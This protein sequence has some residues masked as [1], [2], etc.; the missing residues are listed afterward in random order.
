MNLSFNPSLAQAYQS[1]SQ[2]IRVLSENWVF[3]QIYCPSCGSEI[4]RAKSG[5][6]VFDFICKDCREEFELKSKKESLGKKI[7]DGAY[8]T[9]MERLKSPN[10]PNLFLLNY[11]A[12]NY[13]VIN[14]LVI[15]KHFFIPE[16]IESRKPTVVTGRKNVWIGCNI[17]MDK[18][19]E[20]GRIFFVRNQ[21]VEPKPKVL[22]VW[23][24]ALFLRKEKSTQSKGW[25]LDTM[26]CIDSLGKKEFSLDQIYMFE[27]ELRKKYPNNKHIKDKL[28]Q[29]LQILRD[30]GYIDFITPGKYKLSH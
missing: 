19:P 6:P 13:K 24:K 10:N 16:L 11:Q 27:T 25:I 8:Q 3:H 9:M 7:L 2:K 1:P 18:I 5:S 21:V 26:K 22:R 28:R 4:T 14:F 20:A 23:N 30:R 15:P 29:Q 12:N 17:L